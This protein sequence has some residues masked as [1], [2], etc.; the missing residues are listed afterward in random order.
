MDRLDVNVE[1]ADRC[2]VVRVNGEVDLSTAGLLGSE[3]ENIWHADGRCRVEVD[4]RQ[5]S[6]MDCA[7]LRELLYAKR[8]LRQ[9]GG[10]LT[11]VN[12]S[13]RVDRLLKMAGLDHRL[14]AV[15]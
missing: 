4:L 6:F 5:V 10:T 11:L 15:P 7:G 2:A 13:P 8:R 9:Q 3:L 14:D 1:I 12:C